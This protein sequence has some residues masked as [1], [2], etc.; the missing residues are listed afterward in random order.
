MILVNILMILFNIPLSLIGSILNITALYCFWCTKRNSTLSNSDTLILALNTADTVFLAIIL[1]SKFM[2]Y[3][4]EPE[5]K[6]KP[7]YHGYMDAVNFSFTSFLISLI[8]I[9]RYIKISKASRHHLILSKGR[10]HGILVTGLTLS[11]L[12]SISMFFSLTLIANLMSLILISTNVLLSVFYALIIRTV[13]LSRRRIAAQMNQMGNDASTT[14]ETNANSR[15][16]RLSHNVLILM[17]GYF[18]CCFCLFAVLINHV[19]EPTQKNKDLVKIGVWFMSLNS[20]INPIIYTLRNHAYQR[21][22]KRLFRM[23]PGSTVEV[24]PF[25]KMQVAI[26]NPPRLENLPITQASS[27]ITI[28]D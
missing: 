22:I 27:L 16:S 10:L 1:P 6:S 9:N 21:I 14:E 17:S 25:N 24:R 20:V 15:E 12:L 11:L 18:F 23:N 8:A 4:V 13:R 3:I 28:Q 7:R 26:L 19:I 5:L 2:S